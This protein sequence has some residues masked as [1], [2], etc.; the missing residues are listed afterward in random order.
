MLYYHPVVKRRDAMR[1]ASPTRPV[2]LS[3]NLGRS[4]DSQW[5]SPA[6]QATHLS[7]EL[8]AWVPGGYLVLSNYNRCVTFSSTTPLRL[9]VFT[10]DTRSRAPSH[11]QAGWDLELDGSTSRFGQR[12]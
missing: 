11:L 7:E 12:F 9:K 2:D 6:F 5:S 10:A 3:S 4:M 8:A 1:A